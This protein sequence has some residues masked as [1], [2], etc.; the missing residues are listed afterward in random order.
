MSTWYPLCSY[1]IMRYSKNRQHT[2]DTV[3]QPGVHYYQLIIQDDIPYYEEVSNLVGVDLSDYYSW[4]NSVD[5]LYSSSGE[6]FTSIRATGID[7]NVTLTLTD[8]SFITVQKPPIILN[9]N[10]QY[11]AIAFG[12][13]IYL[14]SAYQSRIV[15]YLN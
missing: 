7:T 10:N 9:L 2:T 12:N 1:R 8:G 4:G 14:Q 11:S 5:Q 6:A 3:P 13:G 15:E